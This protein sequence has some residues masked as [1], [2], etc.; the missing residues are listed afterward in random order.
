MSAE[1]LDQLTVIAR[2]IEAH[3]TAVWLLRGERDEVR[4]LLAKSEWQPPETGQ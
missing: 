4:A 3:E 1:L 2:K